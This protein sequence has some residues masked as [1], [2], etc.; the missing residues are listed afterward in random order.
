VR[1]RQVVAL[2]AV[3]LVGLTGCDGPDPNNLETYYDD[4]A[5]TSAPVSV[6]EAPVSPAKAAPVTPAAPDPGLLAERALLSD[7]DVAEEGVQRGSGEASGCLTDS[8]S[9]SSRTASWHY[10]SGSVLRH[11]VA[12]YPDEAAAEAVA[13]A[14]CAGKTVSVPAQ[15]GVDRQRAWCE[16]KTCTVLL[17]KGKLVSGLTVSASTETRAV[18]AAKRLLPA[19]TA[20]LA[21]QP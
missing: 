9:A 17:A 7:A 13:A 6:T 14:D 1:H 15:A 5:P 19:M 4:P 3:A 18:D 12:A 21:A 8:S 16:G 2:A 11:R 10:P 20:K